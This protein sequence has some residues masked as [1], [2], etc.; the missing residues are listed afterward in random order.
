[1]E[2]YIVRIKTAAR[3]NL[4]LDDVLK[5][6]IDLGGEVTETSGEKMCLINYSGT[7]EDLYEKLGYSPEEVAISENYIT[8][9]PDTRTLR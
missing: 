7:V 5:K 1:M 9:L 4:S 8:P 6:I 3:D 2:E